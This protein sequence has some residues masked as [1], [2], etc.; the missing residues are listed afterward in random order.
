[1]IFSSSARNAASPSSTKIS[2]IGFPAR[3][4]MTASTSRNATPSRSASMAP[5]VLLPEPGAPTRMI[6][7]S[8]SSVFDSLRVR[9]FRVRFWLDAHGRDHT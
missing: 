3:S 9:L 4:T 8:S 7:P 2:A 6:G 5:T 1:M